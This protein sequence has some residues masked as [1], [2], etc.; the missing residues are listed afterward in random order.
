MRFV[1]LA[2]HPLQRMQPA[3]QAFWA[4]YATVN[5][6]R[7]ALQRVIELT[8]VRLLQ[9]AVEQAQFLTPPS[10]HVATLVQLAE[11]MLRRPEAAAGLLGL[12]G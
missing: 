6:E 9:S 2:A 1:G 7:P 11:N 12:R 10:A 3:M 4:A 5:P 8:A